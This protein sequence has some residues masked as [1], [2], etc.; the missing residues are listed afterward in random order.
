MRKKKG[1]A[2]E[3]DSPHVAV[4]HQAGQY[5]APTLQVVFRVGEIIIPANEIDHLAVSFENAQ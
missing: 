5:K 1:R 3:V 4:L 2:L